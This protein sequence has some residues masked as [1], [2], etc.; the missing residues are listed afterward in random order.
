MKARN[1]KK[2]KE[3]MLQKENYEGEDDDV[4]AVVVELEREWRRK[5]D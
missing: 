1:L 3:K 2:N 4:A 5:E